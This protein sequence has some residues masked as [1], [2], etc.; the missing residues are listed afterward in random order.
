MT[1]KSREF[2]WKI[3]TMKFFKT[4]HCL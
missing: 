3:I 2:L 1:A 4:W